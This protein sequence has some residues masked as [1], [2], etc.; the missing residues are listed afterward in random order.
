MR[1]W[2]IFAPDEIAPSVGKFPHSLSFGFLHLLSLVLESSRSAIVV[3]VGFGLALQALRPNYAYTASEDQ[4]SAKFYLS[5][6]FRLKY[7]F[8]YP[9]GVLSKGKNGFGDLVFAIIAFFTL[10]IWWGGLPRFFT[11]LSFLTICGG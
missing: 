1:P 4:S 11:P 7:F 2:W 10:P 8:E 3:A 6:I 9:L 5:H